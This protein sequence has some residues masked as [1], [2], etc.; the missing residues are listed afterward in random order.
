MKNR[1]PIKPKSK[2]NGN[3]FDAWSVVHL[4][5][6]VLFGWIMPPF[7]ALAIMVLWE[8]LEILV[9]SPLLARQGITF[10][11]ESLRNSLSDIFFDVVGVALGAWLLT[12]VAAAPFH[13]F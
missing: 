5:T 4:M 6:G 3:L 7:T 12:E 2:R 13:V 8:P 10:G 1:K 11:Y 9:L